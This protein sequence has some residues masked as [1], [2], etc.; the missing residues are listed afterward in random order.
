MSDKSFINQIRRALFI[1]KANRGDFDQLS[2]KD[3]ILKLHK[4][5]FGKSLDLNNPI[6]FNEKIEWLKLYYS[7]DSLTPYVDKYQVKK[8]VESK[9][10]KKFIIPLL[11]VYEKFSD[12]DFSSL[13]NSFVLKCTHDS[14]GLVL[15][16]DKSH[17]DMAQ[18]KA[19]I[20][21]SLAND[22]YLQCRERPY[23][24]VP[25]RII[26]E[27]MIPTPNGKALLDYKFFCFDGTPK[28]LF[29]A[30]DRYVKGSH[31]KFDFFDMD[32]K[33]L[34]IANGHPNANPWP[35]KPDNF[36]DM[37]EIARKLSVGFPFVRIDLYDADGVIYF[38][39]YTFF[40]NGGIV[41][42]EPEEWDRTFGTYLHLP[43]NPH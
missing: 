25:R 7:D 39:E 29:V 42:F 36:S 3:Y 32:W 38:G 12:I 17:L 4:A 34:P 22:Y 19:T 11:G 27:K 30:T 28:F 2:D 23:K 18:A 43:T 14:G 31:T 16:R 21:R 41:H 20:E 40:H 15:C 1:R 5:F 10:G 35:K 9:I 24:Y 13:P 6:T 26:A 8:I 33:H 37:V